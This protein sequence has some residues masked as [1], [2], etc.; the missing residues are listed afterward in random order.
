MVHLP[1]TNFFIINIISTYYIY[2]IYLLALFIVQN[3]KKIIL[4]DA[5]LLGCAIFG[6]KM[7]HLP[8]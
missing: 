4:A 2:H 8:K 3:F 5:E 7:A 1:H 6:S